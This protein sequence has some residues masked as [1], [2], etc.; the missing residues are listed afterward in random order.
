MQVDSYQ[1]F[2]LNDLKSI[3][4]EFSPIEDTVGGRWR[5]D[6][7]PEF[8][9]ES[10]PEMNEYKALVNSTSYSAPLYIN[11]TVQNLVTKEKNHREFLLVKFQ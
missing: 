1:S 3:L 7:G 11:V 5:V 9:L 4:S 10:D 6:L 8:Y 2:W